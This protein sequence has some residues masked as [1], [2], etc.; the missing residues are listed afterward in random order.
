[1]SSPL[2]L[3]GVWQAWRGFRSCRRSAMA[4]SPLATM[5]PA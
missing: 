4:A 5:G 2:A 3:L 1:M